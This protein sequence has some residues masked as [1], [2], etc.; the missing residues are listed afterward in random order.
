[1]FHFSTE[2]MLTSSS[3]AHHSRGITVLVALCAALG[4]IFLI[5]LLGL[6]LNRV[7]RR[8]QGYNQVPQVPYQDKH[9]NI[10]RVPPERLFGSLGNKSPP[11]V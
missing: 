7:Q 8:R 1:M 2:S 6:I 10:N 5:I 9:S 3:D 11:Q 4:T